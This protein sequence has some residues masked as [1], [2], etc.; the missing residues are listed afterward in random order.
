MVRVH[1]LLF[2][3]LLQVINITSNYSFTNNVISLFVESESP[4]EDNSQT[5][6]GDDDSHC[7]QTGTAASSVEE[8]I[9][10]PWQF[11]R[12]FTHLGSS[13]NEVIQ[14]YIS[15]IKGADGVDLQGDIF[16]PDMDEGLIALQTM[17]REV[18]TAKTDEDWSFNLAPLNDFGKTIDDVL[19][20]F[21]RWSVIDAHS[22][23]VDN[24][25]QLIG[26]V[27][28]YPFAE[29]ASVTAEEKAVNVSKAFRRLTSYVHWMR[30]VSADLIDPPV[31]YE[32][33]SPSLSI[34][35]VHVT[36]DSCNR[37]VWWI[38]LG[39]TNLAALK[40]HSPRETTRMF[41]WIAHLLFLDEKAQTKGFIVVD[42]MA[43]IGFWSYMTMLPMQVG[44][45][46]D[47]FLISVCPL[48]A[49]NVVMMHR[50]KWMEIAYGLLSWFMTA[51]MKSRVTMVS[52]GEEI[53]ILT[54]LVGGA[55]FIP[56]DY[57]NFHG[58][59]VS[60]VIA[61]HRNQ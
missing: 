36:H 1:H 48:K 27:N 34:F 59:S 6:A 11:M 51:K 44:I 56:Q 12:A 16:A 26:G 13:W 49:K 4:Q 14:E 5:C 7:D 37:L 54:K 22:S 18:A 29:A 61:K 60:D 35:A 2:L 3:V 45:S 55:E 15:V 40:S 57:E 32:S 46:L 38:N 47:R 17:V 43:E 58:E 19:L 9:E 50:P 42:D 8:G 39:K 30:T 21:L 33:I 20:A 23:H 53:E 28:Y 24:S 52:T 31:T 41:V 25:C 10:S